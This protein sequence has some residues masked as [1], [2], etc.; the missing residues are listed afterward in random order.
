MSRAKKVNNVLCFVGFFCSTESGWDNP[1]RPG[2]DL[3]R[4]ADEI[5]N[6]IK[7]KW[8]AAAALL[9]EFNEL[10]WYSIVLGIQSNLLKKKNETKPNETKIKRC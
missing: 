7:G 5:V 2:G 8:V 4:E 9:S 6:M 1:F 10:N 3:S